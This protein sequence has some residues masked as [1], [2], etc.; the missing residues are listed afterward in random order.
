[1]RSEAS[2][3]RVGGC[4]RSASVP[5]AG[6]AGGFGDAPNAIVPKTSAASAAPRSRTRNFIALP[7]RLAGVGVEQVDHRCVDGDR[8]VLVDAQPE[9]LSGGQRGDEVGPC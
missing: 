5:P 1:M 6:G 9:R 8:E 4:E 7:Q 3:S 2:A